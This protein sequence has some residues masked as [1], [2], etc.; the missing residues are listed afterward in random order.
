MGREAS[1]HCQWAAESGQCKVLLETHDLIVRGP[2]RRRVPISSLTKVSVKGE[3]LTFRAGKESVSLSLGS[4][5]ATSWAKK[6]AAPP[7]TLAS[8]LGMSSESHLLLIGELSSSELETATA[9]AGTMNS[10][11]VNLILA[12]VKTTS[13]LNHVL[14][15]YVAYPSNPPVWIVYLK[16]PNKPINETEIRNTLRHEGFMDVKVASVSATHTA[17]RFIKR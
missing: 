1:C 10:R 8:K 12:C 15:R 4:E 2:I 16:G 14:D 9:E 7:P 5:L 6:I 3:Q 13:D 11:E 17:L